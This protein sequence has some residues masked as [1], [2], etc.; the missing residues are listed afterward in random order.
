[1]TFRPL[2]LQVEG[3]FFAT[4]HY[5]HFNAIYVGY[6]KYAEPDR[7]WDPSNDVGLERAVQLGIHIAVKYYESP[8]RA[9]I[10]I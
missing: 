5:C 4:S 9:G 3:P 2:P 10:W 7:L 8:S 1:L 6:D